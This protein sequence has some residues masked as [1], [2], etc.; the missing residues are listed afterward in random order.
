[1][2]KEERGREVGRKIDFLGYQFT[3][4]KTLLRKTT[5]K[6]FC[7]RIKKIK[8][9][10]R[11]LE[12]LASYNGWCK[13]GDCKN[14][15]NVVT[16]NYMGFAKKG[17]KGSQQTKDGRK[18]YD[19]PTSRLM[20]ILNVPITVVDFETNIKT[21]QG[22]DRYCIL[23]EINGERRK[24]ITN[25]LS[26]KDVLDQAALAEESGENIFP[27][28]DV[29]IRRRQLNEGKSTYYFDE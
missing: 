3:R 10:K 27:V 13:Y 1:M 16:D 6:N 5:K 11:R 2:V 22:P 29:I 21:K 25:C 26:L 4:E 14:L 20:D 19:V 12:I 15:W 7:R 8:S 28:Q 18:F 23:F 24:F 17:I 9:R